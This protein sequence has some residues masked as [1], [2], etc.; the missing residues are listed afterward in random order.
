M[1][2]EAFYR[3]NGDQ[4]DSEDLQLAMLKRVLAELDQTKGELK[5]LHDRVDVLSDGVESFSRA[6]PNNDPIG[7]CQYHE[8]LIR[9]AALRNELIMEA[10]K[11]AAG[12]GFLLGI[13]WVL[14]ALFQAFLMELRK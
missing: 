1:T 12:A 9:W 3:K 4:K 11:K 2:D 6:F 7:H 5:K 10:L 14:Y 8:K 13:G